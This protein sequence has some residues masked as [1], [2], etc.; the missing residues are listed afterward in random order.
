VADSEVR[1]AVAAI[2][3]HP[4]NL[5]RSFRFN[6]DEESGRTVVTVLDRETG[7]IIRQIPSQEIL[8]ISA[9]L[10]A[11]LSGGLFLAELA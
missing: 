6:V 10:D 4:R 7:E 1:A 5:Q 3:N 8:E 2:E 9:R 11:A